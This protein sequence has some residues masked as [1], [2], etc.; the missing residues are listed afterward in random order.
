[1]LK[2]QLTLFLVTA[3]MMTSF[4]LFAEDE[5]EISDTSDTSAQVIA[6]T[7][8]PPSS[9]SGYQ[10]QS[11]MQGM[12]KQ[13]PNPNAS[14]NASGQMQWM[15]NYQQAVDKARKEN[16]YLLL[17]FT[18]SDWCG[19]CKKIDSEV[20]SDPAFARAV[21]NRFVF[22]ELDFPM[23]KVQNPELSQQ[24][25]ELKQKFG[26]SGYPTVIILDSNQSFVAETGYRPGGG[27]SYATYLINLT[28]GGQG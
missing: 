21:G 24:N 9:S 15:T 3:G 27:Q 10:Q 25:N 5:C 6:Q 23:N 8:A 16:K 4:S 2:R 28:Q 26:V 18:G 20:F 13:N 17:F 14:Q 12:K 1:M 19:W 7:N 22:V 11:S